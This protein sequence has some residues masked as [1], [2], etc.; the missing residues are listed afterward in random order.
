MS[1]TCW[2]LPPVASYTLKLMLRAFWKELPF[3]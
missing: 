1:A 3:L 2:L